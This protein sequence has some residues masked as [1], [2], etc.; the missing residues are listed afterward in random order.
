METTPSMSPRSTASTKRPTS[1]RSR[2][3]VGSG[4][5]S[6]P[7]AGRRVSSVARARPV[8]AEHVAQHEHRPLVR[9]EMLKCR[10]EREPD[11]LA[12]LVARLRSG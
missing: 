9:R 8:K 11:R 6:R 10:D 12:H 1:S 4:A 3:E 2:A 5:R 7:L